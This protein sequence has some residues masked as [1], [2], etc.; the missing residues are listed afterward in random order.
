MP[1][2]LLLFLHQ[3][4]KYPMPVNS[5]VMTCSSGAQKPAWQGRDLLHTVCACVHKTTIPE[6]RGG[7]G[8]G[9]GGGEHYKKTLHSLIVTSL[10]GEQVI[11]T[12][13][14]FAIFK[15]NAT[16]S[17]NFLSHSPLPKL[18]FVHIIMYTCLCVHL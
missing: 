4:F 9:G 5:S 11:L 14:N 15:K 18:H 7:G 1:G 3:A 17:D 2:G 10:T 12:Q 6:G 13:E 8:G 16:I